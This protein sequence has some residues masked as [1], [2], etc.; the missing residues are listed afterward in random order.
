[1]WRRKERGGEG[2]KSSAIDSPVGS[3]SVSEEADDEWRDEDPNWQQRRSAPLWI[4]A[5]PQD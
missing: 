4:P 5:L 2:G 3:G 1:M